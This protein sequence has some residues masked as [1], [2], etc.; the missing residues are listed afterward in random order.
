MTHT[1][2]KEK[3]SCDNEFNIEYRINDRSEAL[4]FWQALQFIVGSHYDKGS[5]I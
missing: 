1:L 2:K 5:S 4:V 3:E